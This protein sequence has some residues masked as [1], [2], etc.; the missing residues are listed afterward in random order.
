VNRASG[1]ASRFTLAEAAFRAAPQATE[2]RLYLETMEAVLPGKRKLIIDKNH[3]R[4]HLL[5]L[6]DG[7]EIPSPGVLN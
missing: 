6:E 7:V 1:D 5:L 2:H 4:R 3:G